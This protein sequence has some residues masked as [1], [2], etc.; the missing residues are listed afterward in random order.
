MVQVSV[1]AANPQ[2]AQAVMRRQ[3]GRDRTIKWKVF[4]IAL[5]S[6]LLF[7]VCIIGAQSF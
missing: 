1:N 4:G 2:V 5:Q 3:R 6:A 7:A